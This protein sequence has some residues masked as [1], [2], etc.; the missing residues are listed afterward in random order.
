MLL[1]SS[2]LSCTHFP[3]GWCGQSCLTLRLGQ[4]KWA[5]KRC[6]LMSD[7]QITECLKTLGLNW[8]CAH[9]RSASTNFSGVKPS[10]YLSACFCF[11][12]TANE[13]SEAAKWVGG[14]LNHC[15]ETGKGWAFSWFTS[16][17]WAATRRLSEHG[18]HCS[19]EVPFQ[20]DSTGRKGC[21]GCGREW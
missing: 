14:S 10:N 12:Q 19:A 18:L 15:W 11:V 2:L 4:V 7:H 21:Q 13:G 5:N 3:E 20:R 6:N 1:V 8:P 16:N 17:Q 9:T